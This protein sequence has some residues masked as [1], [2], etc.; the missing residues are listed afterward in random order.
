MPPY[1]K[2]DKVIEECVK[3]G[4]KNQTKAQPRETSRDKG[5]RQEVY[6]EKKKLKQ[7]QTKLNLADFKDF[8]EDY[9]NTK[10]A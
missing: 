6:R 4:V 3:L 2:A 5:N 8:M 1:S 7:T 10:L 9:T